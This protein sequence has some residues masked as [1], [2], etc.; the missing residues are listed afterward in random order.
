MAQF[1][2]ARALVARARERAIWIGDDHGD[3][4]EAALLN[5]SIP[6]ELNLALKEILDHL[7][8]ALD[9][10][11]H[12][13][14]EA[15]TGARSAKP[16]YFPIT[17][18]GFSAVDFPSRVGKLM[19]GLLEKRPD[20]LAVLERF[21]PYASPENGWLADLATLANHT[22]H[23]DLE[24]NEVSAADVDVML[25]EDGNT[26]IRTHKGD[27]SPRQLTFAYAG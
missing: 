26:I 5:C 4:H 19:P 18:R 23:V 8:S 14:C 7:R 1:D 24:V 11:A 25:D 16:I 10:V 13:L 27:G 20:L 3:P 2:K 17:A 21:Q 22:K 6:V 15:A 9:Y 12:E